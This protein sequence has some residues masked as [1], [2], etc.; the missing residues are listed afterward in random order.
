MCER[1]F[2]QMS[3][4]RLAVPRGLGTSGRALW[5][6]VLADFE[7][8]AAELAALRE[9]CYVVDT[10]AAIEAELAG[11]TLTVVGSTGQPRA[12]PLLAEARSQRRVLD[13]LLRALA[14]PA[15]GEDV[16]HRRSPSAREA[17]KARWSQRQGR[18]VGGR[19]AQ[20]RG[21]VADG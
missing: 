8:H 13:Q 19:L 12:H 18:A 2:F 3:S 21:D 10:L 1:W 5:R 15:P 7:L 9:A 20:L 17:A 16:G 6:D 4:R 14:L 11:A